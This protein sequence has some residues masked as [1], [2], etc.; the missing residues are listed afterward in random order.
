MKPYGI[1][2]QD[3][4][5]CPGHSKFPRDRYNNRRS[6]REHARVNQVAHGR[7]RARNRANLQ[8]LARLA[9]GEDWDE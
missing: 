2:R 6:D 7:E 3:R 8:I 5:C 4:S 9:F 1:D